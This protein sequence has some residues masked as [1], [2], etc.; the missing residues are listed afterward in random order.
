MAE[1]AS[2][3]DPQTAQ[4]LLALQKQQNTPSMY[5]DPYAGQTAPAAAPAEA[6]A[7]PGAGLAAPAPAYAFGDGMP[8]S[9]PRQARDIHGTAIKALQ[10]AEFAALNIPDVKYPSLAEI[11]QKAS[12][13]LHPSVQAAKDRMVEALMK[14]K[15]I[16]V[17]PKAKG[18]ASVTPP[19]LHA[20]NKA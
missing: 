13:P 20:A 9:A 4:L 15:G 12:L 11:L 2:A 5:Y 18:S 3:V 16:G 6:P 14:I 7:L 1:A 10:P 17:I 8:Q 19:D